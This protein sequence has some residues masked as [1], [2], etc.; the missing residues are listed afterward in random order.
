MIKAS[1]K[2]TKIVTPTELAVHLPPIRVGAIFLSCSSSTTGYWTNGSD[3]IARFW[4][5]DSIED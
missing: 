2:P 4:D 5:S 3:G 1:T